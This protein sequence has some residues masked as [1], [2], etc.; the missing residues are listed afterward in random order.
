VAN[1]AFEMASVFYNAFLPDVATADR[2]GRVSGY[3]WSLGYFGGLLALVVALVGF[4][5]PQSPW[6]GFSRVA[7]ENVR[8][9]NLLVASWYAVCSLPLLLWVHEERSRTTRDGHILRA[10]YEQLAV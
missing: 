10:S 4:V 9:T 7:G 2:I 5:Q 3:G 1:I 8:A 6:F